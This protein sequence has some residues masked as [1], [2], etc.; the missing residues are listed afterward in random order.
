ML[1]LIEIEVLCL[2]WF[3][4]SIFVLYFCLPLL[5]SCSGSHSR[6][7]NPVRAARV[8]FSVLVL[9]SVLVFPRLR[10]GVRCQRFSL[11]RCFLRVDYSA[12]VQRRFWSVLRRPAQ[13]R[14]VQR[15]LFLCWRAGRFSVFAFKLPLS[16]GF[17]VRLGSLLG[18]L[19]AS[20][21]VRASQQIGFALHS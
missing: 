4:S 1:I 3:A 11:V 5:A 18:V 19:P 12:L 14:L 21:A 8:L 9:A 16:T 20:V 10:A 2:W 17:V 15:V 13:A 7:R 6:A